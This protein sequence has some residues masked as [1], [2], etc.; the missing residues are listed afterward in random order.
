MNTLIKS[1]LLLL[2]LVPQLVLAGLVSDSPVPP[3]FKLQL[4]QESMLTDKNGIILFSQIIKVPV[5]KS[6]LIYRPDGFCYKGIVTEIEEGDGFFKIYGKL[7][8]VDAGFGFV[9]HKG[10]NFAGA[11]KE[12]KNL[13]TYVAEFDVLRKGFVFVYSTKYDK[14]SA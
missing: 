9:M 13:K 2:F 7:H 11:I 14:P 10:G 1:I 3:G 8:N 4:E 12:H 6:I 5:G